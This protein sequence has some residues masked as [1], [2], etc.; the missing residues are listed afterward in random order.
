MFMLKTVKTRGLALL[1][2]VALLGG[3]AWIAA[4]TTGAYFSDTHT[5]TING[6][7]GSIQVAANGSTGAALSDV[8]FKDMLPGVAQ[9]VTI[10]Y[11]NTGKNVQDV[12]I[13]FTNATA[14]SA[15]NNM[16]SYGEV[17]LSANGTALF[18][19]ANLND[20]SGTCGAFSPSGCWPLAKQ[21]KVASNLAPGTS[22]T[23]S[24]TFAL[25]GKTVTPP[26]AFNHYPASEHSYLVTGNKDD[27]NYINAADGTGN[28]L[29]FAI[30]AT[31]V[32]QQPS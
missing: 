15:L 17:H 29:P 6:S 23:V 32:G 10:N 5:G 4:G 27:Q 1:A 8:S 28:G 12:W 13:S 7:I 9:T 11:K 24:F 25:A 26:V 14:L 2:T 30:V 3:T 20:R 21:Y 22:G 18:D 16:G 31:Q 19:S